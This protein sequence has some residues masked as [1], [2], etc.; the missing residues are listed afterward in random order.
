MSTDRAAHEWREAL[1]HRL[2]QELER[3]NTDLLADYKSVAN[4]FPGA[5]H[6]DYFDLPVIDSQLL[7]PWAAER[8]WRVQPA[9][10][11]TH[12]D[13]QSIPRIRFIHS[14]RQDI[15][16]DVRQALELPEGLRRDE[17]RD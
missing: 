12:E 6:P 10:E 11:A 14:S 1:G 17:G 2:A 9:P 7:Q 4:A 13:Q 3:G 16:E 5:P 15:L 8:G